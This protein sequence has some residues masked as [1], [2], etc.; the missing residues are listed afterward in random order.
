MKILDTDI[1]VA[2]LRGKKD[3]EDLLDYLS[4][5]NIGCCPQVINSLL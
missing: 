3:T 1:L 2:I 4:G 5:E